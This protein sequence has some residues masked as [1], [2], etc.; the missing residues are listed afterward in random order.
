[1]ILA[2]TKTIEQFLW[3]LKEYNPYPSQGWQLINPPGLCTKFETRSKRVKYLWNFIAINQPI[4]GRLHNLASK[5]CYFH[6]FILLVRGDINFGA[7]LNNLL[8]K[9]SMQPKNHL[10]GLKSK[11]SV[12]HLVWEDCSLWMAIYQSTQ[13]ST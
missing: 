2:F 1:M 9:N 7:R 10:N 8:G 3:K 13:I 5:W 4:P 12:S 11:W 6:I